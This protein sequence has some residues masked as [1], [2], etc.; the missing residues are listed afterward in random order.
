MNAV[1]DNSFT[2]SLFQLAQ[3]IQRPSAILVISAHWQTEGVHVL[4]ADPPEMIY[5][6]YGFPKEL[7]QLQYPAKGALPVSDRVHQL[8]NSSRLTSDWGMDHGAWSV[9][10]HMYPHADI[11]V[12]QLSLN[13]AFKLKDHLEYA[14]QLR[15]LRNEGV[16]I[17]GSGNITHNLRAISS[18][19][20]APKMDW[21]VEF[22]ERI[23]RALLTRDL[24]ALTASDPSL[25]SLWRQNHPTLEHYL[26]LLYI[27]G[28]SYP[29]ETPVFP[30]TEF[31]N[32]S[33]SMR[34]VRY[35][36]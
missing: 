13:R 12:L 1:S 5:D 11:P 27:V 34:S 16:L 14:V 18:E 19:V 3:G 32:G 28:T 22:D 20:D 24:G 36:Q 25:Q 10:M 8:L 15:E 30:F 9:L 4:K 23:S 26:P 35:G 33:L 31:Q 7:Y 2:Q 29:T 21:A 6:F 17:L